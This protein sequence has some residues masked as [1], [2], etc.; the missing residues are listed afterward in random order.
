MPQIT[1]EYDAKVNLTVAK[2]ALA[3]GQKEKLEPKKIK[4]L[5]KH[6]K[7]AEALLSKIQKALAASK[8]SK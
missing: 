1:T 8:K 2:E 7:D 5:K 3:R 6:V 4:L